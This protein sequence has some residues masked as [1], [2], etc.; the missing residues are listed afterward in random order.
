[1]PHLSFPTYLFNSSVNLKYFW[2]FYGNR[3]LYK[4]PA[5]CLHKLVQTIR[6]ALS[7]YLNSG[8][9]KFEKFEAGISGEA[10]F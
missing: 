2:P 8:L 6:D 4:Y 1:M 10:K 3:L 9:E 7:G 5:T